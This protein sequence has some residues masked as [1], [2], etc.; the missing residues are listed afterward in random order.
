MCK[1]V[2][3]YVCVCTCVRVYLCTCVRVHVCV[4]VFVRAHTYVY[5]EVLTVRRCFLLR[6]APFRDVFTY[7]VSTPCTLGAA[8]R[9]ACGL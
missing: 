7:Y 4:Y 2:Q 3:V 6:R 8:V 5:M 9:R 1:H